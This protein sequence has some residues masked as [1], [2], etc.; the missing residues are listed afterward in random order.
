MIPLNAWGAFIISLVAST[1]VENPLQ[2][3]IAAVP[4]NLYA[5]TAIL[6]AGLVIWKNINIGP[7]KK[8]EES[9][10]GGEL[11]WPGSLAARR[12]VGR[13]RCNR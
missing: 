13:A 5:I 4:L 7:M 6:L 12:R 9:T 11:L 10:R 3:F 8:A 1:G 2:T